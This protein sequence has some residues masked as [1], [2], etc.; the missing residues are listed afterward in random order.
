MNGPGLANEPGFYDAA[1]PTAVPSGPKTAI[2][3]LGIEASAG[4]KEAIRRFDVRTCGRRYR[5]TEWAPTTSGANPIRRITSPTGRTVSPFTPAA[6]A[7]N[8]AL[9]QHNKENR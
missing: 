9:D 4:T 2:R 1:P 8:R 7:I 6:R 3:L 5:V